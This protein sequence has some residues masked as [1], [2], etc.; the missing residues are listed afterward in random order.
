VAL[1]KLAALDRHLDVLRRRLLEAARQLAGARELHARLYGVGP[2]TAVALVC[3]LGGAGRFSSSRKAIRFAGLDITV[4][5]S[6][7]KGP[8]GRLSRQGPEVLRWC[9]YEAGKTHARGS[10]P[11]YR[12]YAAVKDRTDGKRAAISEAR[13]I[14]RQ[15]VRILAELG[16]DALAAA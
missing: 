6:D 12:Y 14:I 13:K 9:V 16:D 10:A 3:W 2:I 4:W 5:S 7:R 15:A 8:P 11:D 1:D